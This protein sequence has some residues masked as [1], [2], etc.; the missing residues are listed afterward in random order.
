MEIIQGRENIFLSPGH[1]SPMKEQLYY[2]C[3]ER[4]A[5]SFQEH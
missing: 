4:P 5:N 3:S 1:K 2:Q